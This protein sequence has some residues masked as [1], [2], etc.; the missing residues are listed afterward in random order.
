MSI[1]SD[2]V[3]ASLLVPKSCSLPH[4]GGGDQTGREGIRRSQ[5][6]HLAAWLV[7]LAAL[8]YPTY[9]ILS[10]RAEARRRTQADF[11]AAVAWIADHPAPAGPVL[12]RHP[13]EVYWGTGRLS[14]EPATASLEALAVQIRSIGV[15]YLLDDPDRYAGAPSTPIARFVADRPGSVRLARDGAVRVFEIRADSVP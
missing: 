13:A 12:S 1:S 3:Q 6:R 14:V 7:L 15:A 4:K 10:G 11:D 8:P 5:R 9:A 2:R